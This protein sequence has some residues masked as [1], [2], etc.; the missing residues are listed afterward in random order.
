M[1][2]SP[3]LSSSVGVK[4]LVFEEEPQSFPVPLALLAALQGATDGAFLCHC[5]LQN[6][7]NILLITICK[8]SFTN[9]Q[10]C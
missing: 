6:K 2:V 9:L 10:L 5:H 8:L 1:H 7:V 3:H 4:H